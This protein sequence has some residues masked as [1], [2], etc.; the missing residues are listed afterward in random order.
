M[1]LWSKIK[2]VKEVAVQN[3]NKLSHNDYRRKR[4]REGEQSGEET[5]VDRNVKTSKYYVSFNR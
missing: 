3:G 4:E 2:T 1:R 5:W